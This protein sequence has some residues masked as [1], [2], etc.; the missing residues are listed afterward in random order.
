MTLEQFYRKTGMM[1]FV[2]LLVL[3]NAALFAAGRGKIV[4]S[5]VD[6]ANNEPLPGANVIV[7]GTN[8]G[9]ATDAEG[10]FVIVNVPVGTYNVSA[11]MIGYSRLTKTDVLVTIDRIS[12][13]NFALSAAVIEGQEVTVVAERDVLHKEVSY[14]QEIMTEQQI[15][16]APAIRSLQDFLSKQAGVSENLG[17]RGGSTDQTG[18]IVNGLTFVDERFGQPES[19]IP[20]SAVEQVSVVK[21]GFNA[22]YGNFRSGMLDVVTKKGDSHKYSGRFDFSK[23]IP[24]MKRFGRSLYD[25]YAYYVR[26][27]VDPVVAFEG[28]N[29]VWGSDSYMAQQSRQFIGWNKLAETYNKIHKDAPATPLDLYLW[30]AWM[31]MVEPPFDK[32]AELGYT[33]PADLQKKMKDHAHYPEDS[34]SDWNFDFGFGGPVPL[35]GKHLGNATFFLSHNSNEKAYVIPVTVPS[36]KEN[37][38]MLTLQSQ[39]TKSMKLTLN[40]MY[41]ERSG[42]ITAGKGNRFP[43]GVGQIMSWDNMIRVTS[44][45]EE[46]MFI[47]ELFSPLKNFTSLVGAELT[48]TLNSK[49]YWNLI[50]SRENRVSRAVPTWAHRISLEKYWEPVD[51]QEYFERYSERSK[52]PVAEFGPIKVNEMPYYWSP[53][54]FEIDGF[55]HSGNYEQPFGESRHRFAQ[56]GQAWF[57]SS[58]VKTYRIKFDFSS[59][60]N[61]HNFVKFGIEGRYSDFK[62][63]LSSDWYGH[64]GAHSTF[65]WDKYPF[66][67]AVYAQDQITYEGVVANIGVRAD[68]YDPSGKWVDTDPFNHDA[69]TPHDSLN[70]DE[71]DVWAEQGILKPVKKYFTI[72]PR[73]GLSFP[74]TERAKYYFNYGHFRS[75]VPWRQLYMLRS[76]PMKLGILE[77]GNPNMEPPRTISY[78]TGVEY[79]LSDMFLLRISGYYKDVTGQHGPVNY[80]SMDGKVSYTSYQN[81]NYEDILGA[82]ISLTKTLGQ[83]LTGWANF[84]FLF[85]KS[86]MIG[87]RDY[88]EDPSKEEIEGLYQDQVSVLLA[89][90]NFRA[91]VTFHLPR[92]LGPS[93]AGI[94]PLG[95]WDLSLLPEWQAG[96]HFTYNPLGKIFINNNLQWPDYYFVD[97]R[98]SKNVKIKYF[99]FDLY[100]N[101]NNL[102]NN[103][104][105]LFHRPYAFDGE[106]D[107]QDYMASLRLPMYDSQEFDALREANADKGYYQPGSDKPGDLRSEDKPYINDPN[108]KLWLFDRPR[109]IWFG[110]VVRF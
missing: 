88:F 103:K 14:S 81:N 62:H 73:I 9:A 39:I 89:E 45:D 96:R 102:F 101:V 71:N 87:R 38:T 44:G 37:T 13:V 10:R 48:H 46:N 98:L 110:I 104:R 20:L 43:D 63:R 100:V 18:S 61:F 79:N 3:A 33:V 64:T 40:G 97:A 21:G 107:Y 77:L 85:R 24:H 11:T 99:D 69:F 34:N 52:T 108:V 56:I 92:E 55:R 53:G 90:P 28:T 47:P 8:L 68:Y 59:Q 42:V 19:T 1:F 30:N 76:R 36:V 51:T 15:I 16:E 67:G 27:E 26:S 58:E 17:I 65:F 109:D 66:S 74:V 80:E 31:H 95:G 41:Q 22:E 57:D 75:T 32:L 94:R 72:S 12:N 5:V 60:V 83:W 35:L 93:F 25:P 84:D 6:A 86:G 7:D 50:V 49:T 2:V 106:T 70:I 91:N 105:P 23:D 82:E 29:T 4:G 54:D 78:E